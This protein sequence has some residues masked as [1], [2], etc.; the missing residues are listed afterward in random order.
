MR[1]INSFGV[2]KYFLGR[3]NNCSN[4]TQ[5]LQET[6]NCDHDRR[7]EIR[8]S[9]IGEG[10]RRKRISEKT[11]LNSEH[12][13]QVSIVMDKRKDLHS[14]S[15]ISTISQKSVDTKRS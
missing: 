1:Q 3:A 10:Y 14:D 15:I 7:R 9:D 4:A 2:G 13:P 5:N 8:K 6:K 12:S 11:E